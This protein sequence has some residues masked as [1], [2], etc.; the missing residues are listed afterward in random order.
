MRMSRGR[1]GDPAADGARSI[2]QRGRRSRRSVALIATAWISG[3]VAVALVAGALVAYAK[4][5]EI[6]DGIHKDKLSDLGKRPPK[7]NSA[8][9]MLIF[10]SDS[11]AG[12]SPHEQ[13]RLHVGHEGCNCS[14]TIMVVHISPGRHRMTVLNLPRDTMVPMYGCLATGKL[15]GQQDNPA[16]MVQINQTLS[17]GGPSCLYKT[18]EHVTGIHLDHFIQVEFAGVVKVVN[19]IGGVEVCVPAPISDPNSGLNIKAGQQHIDG[20]TFLEFWRARYTLADGTDL[21]R[22]DRDDLLLAQMLRGILRS[23]LLSSPTRLIPVV[24]DA[25]RAIYATDAGFTQSDM[26][27][28]ASSF[29]G[30]TSKDVQ[31]IEAPTEVYP[32]A[33]AQVQFVQPTDGQLFSA[34]AHDSRLPKKATAPQPGVSASAVATIAPAKVSVEVLNGSGVPNIAAT[35]AA[36]LTTRGFHVVG[37]GD[38]TATDYTQSVVE[39][40]SAADLPAARTVARTVGH[41]KLHKVPGLTPGTVQLILGSSYS[42]LG[43]SPSA[44]PSPSQNVGNLAKDFGGITGTA[45]CKTDSG[46][47]K[48]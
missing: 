12:L 48:P 25:A 42:T 36:A 8:L 23:G 3:V 26:L 2:R 28:I 29:R 30:L 21:K 41:V 39:Y 4:Y 6:W 19:D 9:N 10:G 24:E 7:Y 5:R 18:V 1:R 11:R 31:F 15:P 44:S 33:P 40:A 14:D 13:A 45:N 35:T 22:I 43:A 46:A 17:H 38:A 47:F 32:P 16:A 34:I 20:L 37:T 27:K